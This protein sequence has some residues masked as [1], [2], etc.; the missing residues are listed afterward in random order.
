MASKQADE[1]RSLYRGW[2]GALSGGMPL[3]EWRDMVERWGGD[4]EPGGTDY[5]EIDAGGVPAMWAVPKGGAARTGCCCACTAA[6]LW[7]GRCTP[8][9]S[10]S[11]TLQRRP[12]PSLTGMSLIHGYTTG[13]W[14]AAAIFAAGAVICG[15]LFRSGPL[16]PPGPAAAPAGAA[17]HQASQAPALHS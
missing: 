12:A 6:A 5:L 17:M 2:S 9:A 3:E 14:V 13:F 15:T 16:R 11:V 7:P 10:C 4:G 8:T 1:L